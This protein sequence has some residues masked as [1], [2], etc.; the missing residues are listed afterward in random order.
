MLKNDEKQELNLE[1]VSILSSIV[2][3]DLTRTRRI[4]S[5]RVPAGDGVI[6]P[7]SEKSSYRAF[8]A[9]VERFGVYGNENH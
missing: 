3:E 6:P 4:R 2:T 8:H 7:R 9:L 1:P 5:E